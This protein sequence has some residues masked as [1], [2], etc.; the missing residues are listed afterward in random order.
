MLGDGRGQEGGWRRARVEGEDP[1]RLSA[2]SG[3]PRTLPRGLRSEA[4]ESD[5]RAVEASVP[6]G[7]FTSCYISTA[8]YGGKVVL[9]QCLQTRLH[10][11]QESLVGACNVD[12]LRWISKEVVQFA[13]AAV[14]HPPFGDECGLRTR[15]VWIPR[16]WWGDGRHWWREWVVLLGER[17]WH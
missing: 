4:S 17:W 3:T 8:S 14:M 13:C 11:C 9:V 10:R 5:E 15:S 12:V 1:A 16:A 2:C 6:H 7:L